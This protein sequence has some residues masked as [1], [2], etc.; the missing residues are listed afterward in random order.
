MPVQTPEQ[1]K[2][3]LRRQIGYEVLNSHDLL[4]VSGVT[5]ATI[6]QKA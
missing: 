2:D 4:T 5:P 6:G 1:L 3:Q